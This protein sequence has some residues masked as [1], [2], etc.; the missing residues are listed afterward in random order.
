M[1]GDESDEEVCGTLLLFYH[2]LINPPSRL[3]PLTKISASL[4]L[5]MTWDHTR[6]QRDAPLGL[7]LCCLWVV[8]SPAWQ[9]QWSWRVR[10]RRSLPPH[11]VRPWPSKQLK[12]AKTT[13]M[14]RRCLPLNW[15]K[16]ILPLQ[17]PICTQLLWHAQEAS[18]EASGQ[19]ARI[20]DLYIIY[21][22]VNVYKRGC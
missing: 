1:S 21:C 14:R 11:I 3:L 2:F 9:T 17:I 20:L 6:K 15:S 12:R 7:L 4:L 10:P 16:V 8:P 19:G 5:W 18:A 22:I 13:V